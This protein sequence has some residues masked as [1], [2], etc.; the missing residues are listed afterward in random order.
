MQNHLTFLWKSQFQESTNTNV[1]DFTPL[2]IIYPEIKIHFAKENF[3][4]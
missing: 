3:D 4:F 1:S 2:Y